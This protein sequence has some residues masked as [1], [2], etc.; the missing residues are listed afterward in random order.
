MTQAFFDHPYLSG[1][2]QPV[3]FEATAPDLIIAPGLAFDRNGIR[4]G[5]GGGYYDRLLAL[6]RHAA[7]RRVGL[8][9]AFQFVDSLPREAWDMPVHAVCTEKGLVWIPDPRPLTG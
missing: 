1:H 2:H 4:L 3:R 7:S 6:P 5:M 8:A 9:F